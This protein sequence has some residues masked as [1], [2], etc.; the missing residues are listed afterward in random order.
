MI[1]F[2]TTNILGDT[3]KLEGD[4][5]QHCVKVLRKKVGDL[6]VLVDGAGNRMSA[7][8][9]EIGKRECNLVIL[10]TKHHPVS[11]R[12]IAIGIAPTK[13]MSRFEWLLEKSTELGITDIYPLIYARSERKRINEARCQ[14]IVLSAFKQSL[15]TDLP[16]L[17][18]L[19][20]YKDFIESNLNLYPQKII[21]HYVEGQSHIQELITK[22]VSTITFIGP[23][24]D[25]IEEELTKAKDNGCVSMNISQN[26]LRTETA[27][28][29]AL[30]YML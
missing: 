24:G 17:H 10:D 27:G 12:K 7:K 18:S 19:Q 26:R 25:F 3:A 30:Q 23:E 2:F 9:V 29:V 1:V 21:A 16:M 4:E 13:N 28:L 11:E 22:D 8:L 6:L 5:H 14:K 15:R 20:L